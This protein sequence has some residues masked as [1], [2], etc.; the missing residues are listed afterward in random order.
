MK[1]RKSVSKP[2]RKESVSRKSKARI[3][4]LSAKTWSVRGEPPSALWCC[5]LAFV[6]SLRAL[7]G[8]HVPTLE[9]W[10][11]LHSWMCWVPVP[12]ACCPH[13][14]T[15]HSSN[16]NLKQNKNH[17]RCWWGSLNSHS[18][19]STTSFLKIFCSNSQCLKAGASGNTQGSRVLDFGGSYGRGPAPSGPSL[20]WCA[21]W[22]LHQNPSVILNKQFLL[23]QNS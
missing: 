20:S 22:F 2:M 16:K 9:L 3:L 4:K 17:L 6:A 13:A 14:P 8:F 5:S 19:W 12:G 7:Q 10:G 23:M 18:A 11:S 21:K 15:F 1:T